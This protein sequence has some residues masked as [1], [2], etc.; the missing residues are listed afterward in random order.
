MAPKTYKRDQIL[1]LYAG[2]MGEIKVRVDWVRSTI[3]QPPQDVPGRI[4]VECCYLQLR[5]ILEVIA[6]GCLAAHGDIATKDIQKLW[7]ADKIMNDLERLNPNFFPS[8]VNFIITP[9]TATAPKGHSS[10]R[11]EAKRISNEGGFLIALSQ[12]R[13]ASTQR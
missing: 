13:R 3:A 6:L 12:V 7:V 9:P 4:V 5:L 8:A 1:G 10:H 11:N 2:L